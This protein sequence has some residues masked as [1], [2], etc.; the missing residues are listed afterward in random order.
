MGIANRL[1]NKNIVELKAAA[2]GDALEHYIF[3]I[4]WQEFIED[5]WSGNIIT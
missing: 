1:A 5:L 4:P 3:I 2:A